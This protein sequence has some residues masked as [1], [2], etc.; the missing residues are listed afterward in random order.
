M[1]ASRAV[2]LF[3]ERIQ[4]AAD[5][6]DAQAEGIARKALQLSLAL[7]QGKDVLP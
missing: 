1:I 2:S 4:Q 3:R 6:G 5:Q 7:F